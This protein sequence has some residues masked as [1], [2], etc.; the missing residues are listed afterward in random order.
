MSTTQ[1]STPAKREEWSKAADDAKGAASSVAHMAGH[2]ASA[3][4]DMASE[5]CCGVTKEADK[6]AAN[7]GAGIHSIGD[8]LGSNLPHDGMLGAA[9]Q[10]VARTVTQGGEYLESAKLSGMSKDVTELVRKNP[11]PAVLIAAGLGWFLARRVKG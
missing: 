1:S 2:A 4:G 7:A 9:S 8:R 6:L 10:S 5:A 3:V 11:L